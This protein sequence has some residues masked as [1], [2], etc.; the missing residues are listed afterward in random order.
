MHLV[1]GFYA[2]VAVASTFFT[3]LARA[4]R[5]TN[6]SSSDVFVVGNDLPADPATLG[7]TMNHFALLVNDLDAMMNFYGEVLG[8]RHIFTYHATPT[9]EI[10]YSS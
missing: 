8:M 6:S 1:P 10:A 9:F 2:G 5:P 7:Y 4:C 3:P